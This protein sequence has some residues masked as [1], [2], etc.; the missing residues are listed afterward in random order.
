MKIL[1]KWCCGGLFF[2]LMGIATFWA[3]DWDD[4]SEIEFILSIDKALF[5][6]ACARQHCLN[7][8]FR[9]VLQGVRDDYFI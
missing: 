1:K 2:R 8:L 3:S 6:F 5:W 9:L 7:F 4:T